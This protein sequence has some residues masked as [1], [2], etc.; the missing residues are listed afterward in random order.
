[1]KSTH[2]RLA[3]ALVVGLLLAGGF[4]STA[5]AGSSGSALTVSS[6]QV[7]G[8]TVQVMVSNAAPVPAHGVVVVSVKIFGFSFT[9]TKQVSV[10][11]NGNAMANVSFLL[12]VGSVQQ[13]GIT[14][15]STPI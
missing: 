3:F 2:R 5:S 15:E 6:F 1:M 8:N 14:D 7:V 9:A 11:A 10:D 13:V 12:P 4:A